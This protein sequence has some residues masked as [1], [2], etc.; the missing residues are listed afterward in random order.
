MRK[1]K[2][3]ISCCNSHNKI[4]C[5]AEIMSEQWA[6][7]LDPFLDKGKHYVLTHIPSGKRVWSSKTKTT[8]KMLVQ[9]PAFFET[10]HDDDPQDVRRL[11]EA[12][13]DFCDRNTDLTSKPKKIGWQ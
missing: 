2:I 7:H 12:I 6:I 8:L 13:K 5:D 11:G 9:E 4:E 10:L 3:S 1:G